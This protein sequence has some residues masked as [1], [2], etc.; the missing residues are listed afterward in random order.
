MAKGN[1]VFA[2][3]TDQQVR[4]ILEKIA[5]DAD[6]AGA[7]CR[8]EALRCNDQA[9]SH[10]F[11]VVDSMLRGIG[12]LADMASGSGV[13]GDVPVWFCGPNFHRDTESTQVGARS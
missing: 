9:T 10:I 6:L 12:A 11:Y 4:L 2:G 3:L 5:S 8:N 13:V 7:V 1:P